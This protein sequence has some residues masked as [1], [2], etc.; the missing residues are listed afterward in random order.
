MKQIKFEG[1][2]VELEAKYC[3]QRQFWPKYMRQTLVLVWNNARYS[4]CITYVTYRMP[5]H[6][7]GQEAIPTQLLPTEAEDLPGEGKYPKDVPMLTFLAYF[8]PV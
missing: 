4:L 6:D 3:F 8:Q 7:I 1:D 5:F 2:W